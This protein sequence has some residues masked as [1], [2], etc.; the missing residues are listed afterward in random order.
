MSGH[1][2]EL[3]ERMS[4]DFLRGKDLTQAVTVYHDFIE[5]DQNDECSF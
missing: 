5:E 3:A 4:Q 2:S 1:S